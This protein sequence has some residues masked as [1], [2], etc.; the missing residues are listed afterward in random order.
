MAYRGLA[1]VIALLTVVILVGS[2]LVG[3]LRAALGACLWVGVT[4]K[5]P[6]TQRRVNLVVRAVLGLILIAANGF[7]ALVV[8]FLAG[9]SQSIFF[10]AASAQQ[11]G[12]VLGLAHLSER[13]R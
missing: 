9:C 2:Y 4:G 7:V 13:R 3:L 8:G 5:R 12:L 6:A 1:L 11:P 10:V